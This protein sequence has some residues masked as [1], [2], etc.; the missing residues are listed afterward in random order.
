M[1]N[2][3]ADYLK[4]E[5][6]KFSKNPSKAWKH[7]PEN[8]RRDLVPGIAQNVSIISGKANNLICVDL[9]TYNWKDDHP[10]YKTILCEPNTESLQNSLVK[11]F[12]TYTVRTS[13]GGLHLLFQYDSELTNTNNESLNIDVKSESKNKGKLPGLIVMTGSITPS[14]AHRD[15]NGKKMLRKYRTVH[16]TTVKPFPC[17]LKKWLLDNVY[18]APS[19]PSLRSLSAKLDRTINEIY[20]TKSAYSYTHDDTRL[21]AVMSNMP[22]EFNMNSRD[23]WLKFTT[24]CKQI[25]AKEFWKKHSAKFPSKYDENDNERE[26]D[27]ANTSGFDAFY[28]MLKQAGMTELMGCFRYAPIKRDSRKPDT[29]IDTSSEQYQIDNDT[30]EHPGK[31]GHHLI[32]PNKHYVIKSDTGTGKTTSF[33]HYVGKYGLDFHSVVSHLFIEKTVEYH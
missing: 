30:S 13:S 4:V 14:K 1:K 21:G 2:H 3:L 29:T 20:H 18:T 22:S 23:D 33:K 31:L 6:I 15:E 11:H 25:G 16:D 26:W 7:T 17:N 28:W 5:L 8:R 24:A 10:F 19:K 12:D 27:G 9:D 32:K